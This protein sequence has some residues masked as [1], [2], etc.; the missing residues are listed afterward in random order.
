MEKALR[1]S[2]GIGWNLAIGGAKTLLG[3]KHT[4][5]TKVKISENNG[6]RCRRLSEGERLQRKKNFLGKSHS[7]ET[8]EK[9]SIAA[10]ERISEDKERYIGAAVRKAAEVNRSR[11]SWEVP[12]ANKDVW[13]M[14]DVFYKSYQENTEMNVCHLGRLFSIPHSA[15]HVLFKK[16]KAGWVPSK[17][18]NWLDFIKSGD[19]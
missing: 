18:P 16:L 10:L 5:A 14:A 12:T 19:L 1:P 11:H 7:E 9:L 13:K 3:F 8:K 4:D 6:M 2:Q 15:L 17:D